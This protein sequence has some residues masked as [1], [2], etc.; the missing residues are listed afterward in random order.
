MEEFIK[1]CFKDFT[2]GLVTLIVLGIV[3]EFIINLIRTIR[4]DVIV[5]SDDDD[6]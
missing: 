5:E 6:D 3:F 4:G 2:S 1:W